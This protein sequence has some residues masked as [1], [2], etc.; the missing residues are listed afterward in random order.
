[1][2]ECFSQALAEGFIVL[3]PTPNSYKFLWWTDFSGVD[4]IGMD[5]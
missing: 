2:C 3:A 1:M 5:I 4:I